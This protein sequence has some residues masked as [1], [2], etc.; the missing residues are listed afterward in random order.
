MYA[1][2]LIDS[3]TSQAINLIT[4]D[5]VIMSYMTTYFLFSIVLNLIIQFFFLL[6]NMSP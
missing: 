1:K 3:V 2:E 4:S 5:D 6:S